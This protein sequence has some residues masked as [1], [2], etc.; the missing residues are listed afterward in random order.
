MADV[1]QAAPLLPRRVDP[2]AAWLGTFPLSAVS[3]CLVALGAVFADE[4]SST[5][6]H[7]VLFALLVWQ[8]LLCPRLYVF[9]ELKIYAALFAWLCVVLFWTEDLETA[10][11]TMAPA[12][13]CVLTLLLFGSLVRYHEIRSVLAGALCGFLAAA[14]VY[15]SQSGFPFN[16]PGQFSYNAVSYMYHFGLLVSVLYGWW[17]GSRALTAVLVAVTMMHVLATTSIKTNMGIV[18]GVLVAALVYRSLTGRILRRNLAVILVAVGAIGYL[19]ATSPAVQSRLTTGIA[20]LAIGLEVLQARED[21]SG[22]SGFNERTDWMQS[23]LE[24]WMRNPIFGEGVEAFRSDY[25]ATSHSTVVD[26]L[27]NT[28]LVGFGL[29][30]AVLGSL[31]LR[32]FE[33]RGRLD[34]ALGALVLAG[35]TSYAFMSLSGNVFYLA[36]LAAFVGLCAPLLERVQVAADPESPR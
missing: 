18:I 5:R 2:A 3:T 13:N 10:Q 15:A 24:S 29:F 17:R 11:N 8:V 21:V 35:T 26:L 25:G 22:Y 23:G 14:M 7:A 28:G 33:L 19:L 27:Y 32:L 6:M 34:P 31:V 30:Y 9:R 4:L 1:P 16:L 36:P 20:R 12:L